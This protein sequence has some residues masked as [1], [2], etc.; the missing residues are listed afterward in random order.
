LRTKSGEIAVKIREERVFVK[1]GALLG[2]VLLTALCAESASASLKRVV[3]VDRLDAG[4][5]GL[6]DVEQGSPA[7]RTVGDPDSKTAPSNTP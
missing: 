2:A 6:I 4:S 7:E 3:I 1:I 5:P